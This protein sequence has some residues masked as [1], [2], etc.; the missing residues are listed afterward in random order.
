[1]IPWVTHNQLFV[2]PC[3][4]FCCSTRWTIWR[5]VS[6]MLL[7]AM[8]LTIPFA[9]RGLCRY[10][11]PPRVKSYARSPY[12]ISF[13][14]LLVSSH[15]K[16][17]KKDENLADLGEQNFLHACL[18][19]L[20]WPQNLCD[21]AIKHGILFTRLR[22]TNNVFCNAFHKDDMPFIPCH[23][24]ILFAQWFSRNSGN[25]NLLVYFVP[26]HHAP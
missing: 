25:L 13:C 1:M 21:A 8:F 15:K 26:K 2:L 14:P 22:G 23:L 10:Q 24:K 3:N 9:A 6:D 5:T 18:R 7:Q 20:H 16:M 12:L 19:T 4:F 17:G 11:Y